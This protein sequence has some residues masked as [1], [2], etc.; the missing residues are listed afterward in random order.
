[1]DKRNV[2][3]LIES[4]NLMEQRVDEIEE[5]LVSNHFQDVDVLKAEMMELKKRIDSL[6]K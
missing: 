6:L 4:I 3:L 5:A 1:M 2:V